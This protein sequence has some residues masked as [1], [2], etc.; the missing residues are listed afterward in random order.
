MKITSKIFKTIALIFVFAFLATLYGCEME[1]VPQ[2]SL[3]TPSFTFST[4]DREVVTFI[5]ETL[6]ADGYYLYVYQDDALLGKYAVSAEQAL[7]GYK[8]KLKYGEYALAV[9]AT[10]STKVYAASA[11]S[12][13]KYSIFLSYMRKSSR[14]PI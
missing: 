3:E 4:E 14:R 5:E 7:M 13:K 9:Q 11:V 1:S 8:L 12:S 6:N 10:D 2:T